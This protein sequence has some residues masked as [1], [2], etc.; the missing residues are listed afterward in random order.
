MGDCSMLKKIFGICIVLFFLSILIIPAQATSGNILPKSRIRISDFQVPDLV[1]GGE[2]FPVNVTI[3]NDRFLPIRIQIRVDLLD[4]LLQLIKKDVGEGPFV[5]CP[6]KT[7]KTYQTTC[8]IREGDINW[9][10][11]QYNLQAVLLQKIP[12][13]GIITRDTSMVQG[14]H[15]NTQTWDKNKLRILNIYAPEI[16]D[17]DTNDFDVTITVSNEGVFDAQ[18]WVRVDLVERPSI[19]PELEQYNVLQIMGAQR[20]ELGRSNE[21]CLQPGATQEFTVHCYL[22]NTEQSKATFNIQ[23]ILFVN[24]SGEH[25]QVDSSL[26]LGVSH[27]QPF[28]QQN[29]LYIV[30]AVFAVLIVLLLIVLIVRILY[31]AYYIRKMKLRAKKQKMEKKLLKNQQP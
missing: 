29:F 11:G 5:I 12:V 23:A 2:Q 22:R 28:V 26:I 16:I 3:T 1:N 10:Q 13:L 27:T 21:K 30:I 6:G 20:K 14:L 19:I 25:T 9:Y 15:M 17:E 24:D 4:G 18:T 31:P 7:T 8:L